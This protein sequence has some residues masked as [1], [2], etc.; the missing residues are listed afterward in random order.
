M[1][2]DFILRLR[3]QTVVAL[4]VLV[5]AL[6]VSETFADVDGLKLPPGFVAEK[7]AGNELVPNAYSL[8]VSPAGTTFVSGPGYIKSLVD[9]D[10]D[11]VFEGTKLFSKFPRSG[12][13]GGFAF[14]GNDVL[15]TGDGALLKFTDA[16][17]DGVADGPPVR[18][19]EIKTGGEHDAHGIRKGP[20]GWWY[21]LSGNGVKALP[22]Y[23][24]SENSPV[25]E[26][27]AGFLMRFTADLNQREIYCHGF[28]NAYDFDFN[29][30]GQVFVYDSDGERDISLPWYRPT[31]VFM[32]RAGD[33]AG[34][35][36]RGWKRPSHYSDMPIEIGSLGRGSPTGVVCGQSKQFPASFHDAVF[37]ADWTFGRIVAFREGA[38]G[39][40]D[41]GTD[42]AVADGQFGFAV[43]DLD[44]DNDGSLLVSVGGR[45]TEG[46]VYRIRYVDKRNFELEE[47]KRNE[48]TLSPAEEFLQKSKSRR[49]S[50]AEISEGLQSENYEIQIAAIEALVEQPT[51]LREKNN[52]KELFTH[53]LRVLRN[54][55]SSKDIS[56]CMRVLKV[57]G[58][59]ELQMIMKDENVL[60]PSLAS[61]Y[62]V[63]YLAFDHDEV[64]DDLIQFLI[65][66]AGGNREKP[67]ERM[68]LEFLSR[69][70]QLAVGGCGAKGEKQMF[71]GYSRAM[72]RL[73]KLD[74]EKIATGLLN[75]LNECVETESYVAAEEFG[76]LAAMLEI[77]S[78]ELHEKMVSIMD[79]GDATVPQKIH[80]LNCLC[81]TIDAE[82]GIATQAIRERIV[83]NLVNLNEL[84]ETNHLN[85]DR[86]FYPCME[87]LVRRLIER[88]PGVAALIAGAINGG[89]ND[90]FLFQSLP[91]GLQAAAIERF[92]G[93]VKSNPNDA[94]PAQLGVLARDQEKKYL[95]LIRGFE[96]RPELQNAVVSAIVQ[97]PLESDRA[98][99]IMGLKSN[100]LTT[101]KNSAIGLR[102]LFDSFDAKEFASI[103]STE[104]RLGWDKPSISVRDQLM[105]LVQKHCGQL[106]GYQVKQN[107]TIQLE[108]IGRMR[109]WFRENHAVEFESVFAGD[110][111]GEL[112]D[113][114][115]KIDWSTGNIS[116]GKAVYRTLQCAQ[117]HD[118]GSRLGPML[119]GITKR[120]G[121]DDIFRSIVKPHEQVPER[122]RA[123]LIETADGQI[124]RGTRV[125]ESA[126]GITLQQTDG[127]TV[128]INK[129]DIESQVFSRQSL[130]P[131]G[132]LRDASDEDMADLFAYLKGL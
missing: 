102:R 78:K 117:C 23:F 111:S 120:F 20:D 18:I 119:G 73:P 32:M 116:R 33:G 5:S 79:G 17:Q 59:N 71:V 36:D 47:A 94:T 83:W 123:L 74:N 75:A 88:D 112:L 86:N 28:R 30:L 101:V 52:R 42:F 76:R 130:M 82:N 43:S 77:G 92:A 55:K 44:F 26:P 9:A 60:D 45:G 104:K 50:V 89:P 87:S 125:Y 53:S 132:L 19:F 11:G 100:N 58:T 27:R 54:A 12:V 21:L 127:Q 63:A 131:E 90:L 8:S 107:K 38:D 7:V 93:V 67:S 24:E 41:R 70:G 110:T 122:Y 6:F 128:R 22:E 106:F 57:A 69:Y 81:Q 37:A 98:I 29:S 66:Y 51:L 65:E 1:Q 91:R 124:F 61:S 56:L 25:K 49:L 97:A 108:P 121:R 109:D 118:G 13:Q 39:K 95:G 3:P 34:W 46:A 10:G 103:L 64:R 80:W 68:S 31:R 40:Y 84:I 14:D 4:S 85:T 96:N 2:S 15:G 105:M 99:F 48:F 115:D 114:L 129:P 72:K 126:D 16:D 62:A 35:V 113:R